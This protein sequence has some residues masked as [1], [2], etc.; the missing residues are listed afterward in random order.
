MRKRSII[1]SILFVCLVVVIAYFTITGIEYAYVPPDSKVDTKENSSF[2]GIRQMATNVQ[3]KPDEKLIQ[4]GKQFFY[5]ETFGN[6]IFFTDIM[7]MF[8]G[9]FTIPNVAKAIIN[10]NGKGTDNLQVPAAKSVQIG[11]LTIKK[12]DLIDTGLDVPKGALIPLGVKFRYEEGQIRA[13]ISCA[14]CHSSLDDQKEVIHG[15]PNTDLN[16][17][18]LVA[19]GTNSASYFTHTEMESIQNFIK[20]TERVVKSTEGKDL[21]LPDI[22]A[23]EKYVD[24]EVLK[25]PR[26]GNDTTIDL[27]NNPVQTPDV[28]TLGDHPYGWSGQGQLGPFNGLSAIINNAH[29]QNMDA[30]SQMTVSKALLGIDKE[31]YIATLLQNAANKKYRYDPESGEKPSE[32]LAKVDPTP[33][34][35]GVLELIPSPSYPKVSFLTSVGLFASSEGYRAWEQLNSMSAFMNSLVSPNPSIKT[36]E[37]TVAGGRAIFERAGCIKCHAGQYLT[38]NQLLSPKEIGTES[39][40]AKALNNTEKFFTKPDLYDPETPVP[41]PRNPIIK[42]LTLSA[43]QEKQLKR[44]WG[45]NGSEGAYKVPSLLGLYWSA[46]YLHDGGVAVGQKLNEEIGITATL[47]NGKK[48]DPKNSLLALIDSELRQKVIQENAKNQKLKT[49]HVSGEGHEYWVDH[50]TGFTKEEQK[51]LI[52]YLLTVTEEDRSIRK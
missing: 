4:D 51:A 33:N 43:E 11:D 39:S 23:L 22:E 24:Q 13:G 27:Q 1:L 31:L 2:K 48:A 3:E 41:L 10:L 46:P 28:F 52:M 26:G 20:S 6:E 17:G 37:K 21:A 36:D 9:A 35:V 49:A 42:D 44:S 45:H 29:A 19:L 7:G 18:L 12:G 38:N 8:D 25:W 30:V 14:V 34:A 32:F 47:Y 5:E 15:I 16:I 50:T 40:R